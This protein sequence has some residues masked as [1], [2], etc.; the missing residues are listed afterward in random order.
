MHD[1]PQIANMRM[2]FFIEPVGRS[3]FSAATHRAV[4]TKP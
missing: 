2:N 4:S 3:S 1:T